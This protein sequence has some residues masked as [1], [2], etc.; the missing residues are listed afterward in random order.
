MRF[1]PGVEIHDR[2]LEPVAHRE[3]L[4]LGGQDPVVAGDPALLLRQ[5]AVVL[6]ERLAE[7]G[8]RDG[9]LDAGD[10][11]ADPDLHGAEPW[12]GP[13]VPPDVR[14]VGDA[15]RLLELS[16]HGRVVLVVAEARRS[17]TREG[18]EDRLARGREAGRLAAPERGARRERHQQRQVDEQA[19]DDVDRLVRIVHGH[20]DVEPEDQL[21]AGDVLHL[22]DEGAVAVARGDPLALEEAE[23][24][25]PGRAHPQAVLA[26][27]LLDGRP[28]AAKLAVGLGGGPADGRRDLERRLQLRLHPGLVL[29]ADERGQHRVDPLDEVEALAVQQHVLL[30]DAERVRLA[31]P[32]LVLEDAA[33]GGETLHTRD[34]RGPGLLHGASV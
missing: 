23:R 12:M 18:R 22:V 8:D 33:P 27:D 6:H 2:R 24:V 3:P 19:V 20:V 9:V 14:V 5:L 16:D 1:V 11:V 17:R 4:V 31:L 7:R 25:R 29:V 30:L 13:D 34:R 10:A 21:A 32:E 26:R 28:E 15:A